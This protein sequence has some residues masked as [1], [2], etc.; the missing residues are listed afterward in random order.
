MSAFLQKLVR[1]GNSTQVTIP[2]Q[3]LDWCG[4]SSGQ[5]VIL[6]PR[7]DRT[8]LIRLPVTEDFE[9]RAFLPAGFRRA[10]KVEP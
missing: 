9:R 3:V 5:R 1:N 6:E 4:W 10:L 2:V 7:E 8:I